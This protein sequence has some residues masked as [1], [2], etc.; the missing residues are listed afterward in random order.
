MLGR[1]SIRK[2]LLL[3]A[4]HF[5]PFQGST[6]VHRTLAFSKYLAENGWDVTVLTA[7]PRAYPSVSEQNALAIPPHVRVVRAFAL[8]TQRHLS[9]FGR[10]PSALAVPD[11][12]QSWIAGGVVSGMRIIR[13]WA[14]DA[15]MSTYPIASAH[16]IGAK[17]QRRSGLPWIAD[18]RDPMLQ[19][20]YPADA[21]LRRAYAE[22]EESIHRQAACV[23]VTTEG[24]A[25]LYRERF[26]D[27]PAGFIEIVPNGFDEESFRH[28][29]V[30]EPGARQTP[31]RKLRFLH[32]GLLYPKERNPSDFFAALAELQAEGV[33]NPEDVEFA[34]RGSGNE[35]AYNRDIE[36]LRLGDLVRLLP[37]I[38]YSQALTEMN[39][40][41]ACML[42]QAS[43]C[44]Q[45]I[46]AKVYEYLYCRKPIFALTDPVG[47][48]G[49]LLADLGITPVTP[50]DDKEQIKIALPRFIERLRNASTFTPE[51]SAVLRYSRRNLTAALARVLERTVA[52]AG[53]G[54]S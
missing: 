37:S 10:Y 32:S 4:Y 47:D 40:A 36:R 11:R 5:P 23:T 45:Q 34:F 8:D 2:K 41:D 33:L 18:L 43:N 19:E 42:L 16:V 25:D 22:V 3:V 15:I 7:H 51:L 44:N 30:Q 27:R 24:T 26:R 35:D 46:P 6:G 28:L 20:E 14:P 39:D 53:N 21:R 49:R 9:L 17:L 38:P 48:T 31:H 29:K 1:I 52:A 12:W 50:L 13:E 54:A